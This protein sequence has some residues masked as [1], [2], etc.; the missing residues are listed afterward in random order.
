MYHF[1]THRLMSYRHFYGQRR[2]NAALGEL[3]HNGSCD[4]LLR[5]PPHAF[6]RCQVSANPGDVMGDTHCIFKV[7]ANE[8]FAGGGGNVAY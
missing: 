2:S 4:A 5:I 7:H 1:F 6:E 8:G 3:P